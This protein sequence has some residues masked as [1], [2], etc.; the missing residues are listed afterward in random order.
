MPVP[1]EIPIKPFFVVKHETRVTRFFKTDA[2]KHVDLRARGALL[3]LLV[4]FILLNEN[5]DFTAEVK[6][7]FIGQGYSGNKASWSSCR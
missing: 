4:L 5:K 2:G 3:S 7:V 6:R 1:L